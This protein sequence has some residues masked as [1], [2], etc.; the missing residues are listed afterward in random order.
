MHRGTLDSVKGLFELHLRA[1]GREN[2]TSK[3]AETPT[4]NI[5]TVTADLKR[6]DAAM[7][8]GNLCS[9]ERVAAA[10]SEISEDIL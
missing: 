10:R 3:T 1:N 2:D 5:D 9:A 8:D 6:G 4:G 7:A